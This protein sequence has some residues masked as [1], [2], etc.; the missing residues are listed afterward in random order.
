MAASSSTVGREEDAKGR[1]T[2]AAKVRR[3]RIPAR[4]RDARRNRA[5]AL[6]SVPGRLMQGFSDRL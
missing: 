3:R 1:A 2:S 4:G 5:T 6:S